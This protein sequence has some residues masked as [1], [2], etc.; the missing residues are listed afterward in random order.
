MI[1]LLLAQADKAPSGGVTT[2]ALVLTAITTVCASTITPIVLGLINARKANKQ[3]KQEVAAAEL[4]AAAKL[5][6]RIDE[7]EEKIR[8]LGEENIELRKRI[9]AAINHTP[10]NKDG[11]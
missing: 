4:D 2:A 1:E 3:M 5:W 11:Q 8:E 10:Q 9:A 6:Q 7:L